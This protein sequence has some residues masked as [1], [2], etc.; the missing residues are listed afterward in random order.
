MEGN[1]AKK[2]NGLPVEADKEVLAEKIVN[3]RYSSWGDLNDP[4]NTSAQDALDKGNI[5]K[6]E[7]GVWHL[8][9]FGKRFKEKGY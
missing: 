7:K 2:E 5:K 8:T 6:D 4:F 9:L 1:N 3:P